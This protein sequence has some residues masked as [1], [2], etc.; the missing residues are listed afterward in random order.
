M[1]YFLIVIGVVSNFLARMLVKIFSLDQ[2]TREREKE[3]ER[4]RE[5]ERDH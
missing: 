1:V 4:E 3:R 5:R 2:H